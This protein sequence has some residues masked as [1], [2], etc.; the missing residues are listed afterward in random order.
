VGIMKKVTM[1]Q[2]YKDGRMWRIEERA[3]RKLVFF[4]EGED[5]KW[6]VAE[7]KEVVEPSRG[8]Y[9]DRLIRDIAE[10]R[11]IAELKLIK[12]FKWFFFGSLV[13]IVFW[14]FIF[15]EFYCLAPCK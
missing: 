12:R 10:E 9:I 8:W 7:T 6:K 2:V 13:G 1:A 15:L 4:F 14:F 11:A 5:Y 3:G